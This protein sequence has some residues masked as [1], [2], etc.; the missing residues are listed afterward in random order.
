MANKLKNM[1]LKSVDLVR[2]GAN[3]DA[4]IKLYKS[5]SGMPEETMRIVMKSEAEVEEMIMKSDNLIDDYTEALKDSL[6]SIV[7]DKS[8]SA[9]AAREMMAKSITEFNE[10]MLEDVI[11]KF[12]YAADEE[13]EGEKDPMAINR[14][15]LSKEENEQLDALLKKAAG[16]EKPV[17]KENPEL[18]IDEEEDDDSLEKERKAV[19][20]KSAMHPVVR[21]AVERMERLTKGIEMRELEELAKKYEPLGEKPEELAKTLYDMKQQGDNVYKE[22]V[23]VL[24]KSLNAINKSGLFGE[25]GKSA[26]YG[27]VAK[28]DAEGKIEAIAN[29]IAKSDPTLTKQQA[30]AKAWEQHPELA[31]EYENS[32]R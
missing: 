14:K 15:N 5:F 12:S 22:Y 13:E 9:P 21:E 32:R 24:D 6:S 29:E 18:P 4:D 31:L 2:R 17:N 27:G 23:S 3:P 28:S 30:L 26:Y 20:E 8:L 11:K 16:D 7:N 19:M 1:L 25:I 10:T